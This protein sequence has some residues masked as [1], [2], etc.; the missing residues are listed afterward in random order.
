IPEQDEEKEVLSSLEVVTVAEVLPE[1]D[2]KDIIEENGMQELQFVEDSMETVAVI[3]GEFEEVV[4]AAHTGSTQED[5]DD[6]E[7]NE[8]DEEEDFVLQ[9]SSEDSYD[10]STVKKE[11]IDSDGILET[12]TG[13]LEVGC[14]VELEELSG[15]TYALKPF[16]RTEGADELTSTISGL[17]RR[18]KCTG[19]IRVFSTLS[20]LDRHWDTCQQEGNMNVDREP[21]NEN[22]TKEQEVKSDPEVMP[23]ECSESEKSSGKHRRARWGEGRKYPCPTCGKVFKIPASLRNHE[24]V[25]TGERPF[26]CSLCT[27]SFTQ[28]YALRNHEQQHRGESPY[29]CEQCGKGFFR[30]SDL[31]KHVRS[32]TDERP[33]M[34]SVCSKAFHQLSGLVVH[35][36]IHTGERPY[37]CSFCS[38]SFNQWANKQRHEK[39]HAGGTKPYSCDTCH[40]KFSERKE[41]ELH[42]A[43]HGGGRP[44]GCQ[45]CSKS[46]RKPSE[47][48][49][50]LRRVHTNE[51]PYQCQLCSKA[52]FVPH[53]LKQHL[54][55]HT[56]ERPFTC[57]FCLRKF[58]QKGNL[59]RHHER[60]HRDEV[61]DQEKGALIVEEVDIDDM[62]LAVMET[63]EYE[64]P[65]V[66]E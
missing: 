37:T 22:V 5:I 9:L 34:C 16:R 39:T 49:D 66:T 4:D 29:P 7:V 35:E 30:P 42:R 28:I 1:G 20:S 44:R 64:E 45:Y 27:R 58:R 46:F 59:K 32:H 8:C 2:G 15:T 56:G 65:L 63:A 26:L 10:I 52:F 57:Q 18:Y 23:K 55:V 62:K 51:R 21:N 6:K 54:M 53:E 33:F 19:C 47:L 50:H 38:M 17:R 24:R 40:R 12:D 11:K 13:N 25:H 60:H 14:L 3:C 43:G 41:M 31:E 48:K 61:V 36:R